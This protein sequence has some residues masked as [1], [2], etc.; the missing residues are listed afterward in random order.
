MGDKEISV[1]REL[2][3]FFEETRR[4]KASELLEYFSKSKPKGE[5]IVVMKGKDKC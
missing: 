3:K 4:G 1:T 5:F 2:T